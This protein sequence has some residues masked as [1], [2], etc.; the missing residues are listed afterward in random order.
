MIMI[1]N[2]GAKYLGEPWTLKSYCE[3]HRIASDTL[4]FFN[5]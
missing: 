1:I 4:C 2:P 3:T 5:L